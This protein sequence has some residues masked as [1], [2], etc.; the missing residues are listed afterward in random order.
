MHGA[1][2]CRIPE[3]KA[4]LKGFAGECSPRSPVGPFP[5]EGSQQTSG[6]GGGRVSCRGKGKAKGKGGKKKSEEEDEKK[7][8]EDE[9][10]WRLWKIPT[11][12]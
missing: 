7:I 2:Y 11:D 4:V 10:V 12:K 3:G 5:R 8:T 1:I 6:G 9:S